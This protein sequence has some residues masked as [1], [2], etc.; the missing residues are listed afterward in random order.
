[1]GN[2]EFNIQKNR[3]YQCHY[4]DSDNNSIIVF[5]TGYKFNCGHYQV[6]QQAEI[7]WVDYVCENGRVVYLYKNAI[8]KMW[9]EFSKLK[10]L[11]EEP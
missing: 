4:M 6:D 3:K 8:Q 5:I 10:K 2:W 11:M 9:K 7:I 1:M